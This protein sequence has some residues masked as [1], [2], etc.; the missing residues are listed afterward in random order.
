MNSL[1]P[2]P[3][4]DGLPQLYPQDPQDEDLEPEPEPETFRHGTRWAW[5]RRGCECDLCWKAQS[6]I[7]RKER[8]RRLALFQSGEK[9]PTVHNASTYSNWGCRCDVCV[10]DMRRVGQEYRARKKANREA[11]E[12]ARGQD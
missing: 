10:A 7:R 12:R 4:P 3:R 5:E 1:S 11:R 2:Y 6:L 9:V 8:V